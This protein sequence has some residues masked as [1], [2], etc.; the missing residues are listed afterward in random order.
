VSNAV[1]FFYLKDPKPIA[2][3]IDPEMQMQAKNALFTAM[4]HLP[5]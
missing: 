4:L 1:E 2:V 3:L 5:C